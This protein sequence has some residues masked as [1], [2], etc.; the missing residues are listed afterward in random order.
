MEG[1]V[2]LI[3]VRCALSVLPI[4]AHKYATNKCLNY[5]YELQ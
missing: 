4:K 1:Y 2:A 3:S 5:T